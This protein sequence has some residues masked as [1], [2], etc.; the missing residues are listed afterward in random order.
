M[1]FVKD[2]RLEK[3]KRIIEQKVIDTQEELAEALKQEGVEVTQAT[4]S[5]DIRRL[6]LL[7]LPIGNGRYRY[8]LPL[9]QNAAYAE[10][11]LRI[12]QDSIVDVEF[13]GNIVV[14]KTLPGT[15][16]AVAGFIDYVK[17]AEII[18]TIAGDNTIFVVITSA[19]VVKQV[20]T[21]IK[22]LLDKTS[23]SGDSSSDNL[24]AISIIDDI[25]NYREIISGN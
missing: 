10:A 3:I 24:K 18:G 9:D 21:K 16:E 5:R 20:I 17:W 23:L 19:D 22:M 11:R 25:G 2:L 8:S 15:A 12:F 4:V 6:M 1:D 14:I 7:K 13:S